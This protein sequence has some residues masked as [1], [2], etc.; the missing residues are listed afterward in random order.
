MVASG[1]MFFAFGFD[2]GM[3]SVSKINEIADFLFALSAHRDNRDPKQGR[4]EP[5]RTTTESENAV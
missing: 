2:C 5:P 4:R 3:K 1:R